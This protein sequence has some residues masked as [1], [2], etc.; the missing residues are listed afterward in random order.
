[1][2]ASSGDR[3]VATCPPDALDC[4]RAGSGGAHGPRFTSGQ[5]SSARVNPP[6]GRTGECATRTREQSPSRTRW[7]GQ[8]R[9]I[10]QPFHPRPEESVSRALAG[11]DVRACA[12]YAIERVVVS[13]KASD[14]KRRDSAE[15]AGAADSPR[16]PS[17]R[18][19]DERLAQRDPDVAIVC[20]VSDD[21]QGVDIIRKRG[22][23]IETGTVRR[24]EQGKPIHGEVVRLRPR[25]HFPLICDVEVEVP[26]RDRTD[27]PT[28][29]SGPAQVATETYRKNW[30][31]IYGRTRKP[32][33]MLN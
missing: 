5:A 30:D 31:A 7:S 2:G 26:A 28:P 32:A 22:E 6:T 13:V 3:H 21:G 14:K 24:L 25:E 9:L 10:S 4:R 18:S 17:S 8:R 11:L 1:M 12:K 23:R 27:A 33:S 29:T 20:G 15:Q 16:G 19:S